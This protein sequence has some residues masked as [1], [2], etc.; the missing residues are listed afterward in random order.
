M[1]STTVAL[2]LAL[3]AVAVSAVPVGH[4]D[5]LSTPAPVCMPGDA[6]KLPACLNPFFANFK[7]SLTTLPPY[8]TFAQSEH[9]MFTQQGVVGFKTFCGWHTTLYNCLEAAFGND[10]VRPCLNEANFAQMT[11]LNASDAYGYV[12]DIYY[13]DY[14]CRD[15]YNISISNWACIQQ[16]EQTKQSDMAACQ[17][18][19][20]SGTFS[21]GAYNTFVGC[22][23]NV[24]ANGGCG[25]V[26]DLKTYICEI[27]TIAFEADTT[28]CDS[29]MVQCG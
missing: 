11:G 18:A 17:T 27:E 16:I 29:S 3:L 22:M 5:S 15:G 13:H 21:C 4:A 28:M 20:N 26:A 10:P 14:T 7:L 2:S 1:L 24:W 25:N 8:E 9:N 23:Q 19:L 6:A 12:S